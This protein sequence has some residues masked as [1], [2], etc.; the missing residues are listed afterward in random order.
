MA[1]R[2]I[3]VML[4]ETIAF[5]DCHPG[6]VVV[7]GTLGG[8]GHAQKIIER[9]LPQGVFIGIDR[10][11]DAI[12]NAKCRFKGYGSNVHFFHRNYSQLP[13][14]LSE[15][16]MGDVDAVLLD[17]GVSFHQIDSDGRGFSF[18]RDEKLDM[19]MDIRQTAT[20]EQL[21]NEMEKAEL[22][23]IFR[24]YGEEKWSSRIASK[25]IAERRKQRI[26]STGRLAGI[27]SDAVPFRFR[28][29]GIHPATKVFM[30]LR[31]AVNRELE[32][33]ETFLAHLPDMLR[34]E[35]TVCIIS[36]HSLEDRKVKHCFRTLE[37]GCTCPPK[38][39]VCTCNQKP[40]FRIITR[41]P[42]RPGAEEINR[43][44]MSRSARLRVAKRI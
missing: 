1:F 21:V 2:H 34:P 20:A 12:E 44:P 37:K 6:H 17:L 33:L 30:A 7:D 23:R 3:P 5:L 35:G 39:P 38:L 32:H 19:R 28:K 15:L 27:V 25:I 42:V 22:I 43:N 18:R 16:G 11:R 40:L 26:E 10:D 24:D 29:A 9:I 31:I 4:E 14:I 36:F 13:E 8:G 41:K